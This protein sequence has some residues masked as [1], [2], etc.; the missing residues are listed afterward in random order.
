MH[1]GIKALKRTPTFSVS[2]DPPSLL[3]RGISERLVG[4]VQLADFLEPTLLVR[5]PGFV[6]LGA[7]RLPEIL[8]FKKSY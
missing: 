7:C 5:L 4:V 6:F 3:S 8:S 2:S 1:E